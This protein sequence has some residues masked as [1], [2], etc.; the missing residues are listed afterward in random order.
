M[1]YF[2]LINSK[3]FPIITIY[4]TQRGKNT[5]FG[6]GGFWFVSKEYSGTDKGERK[7]TYE[8]K[9]YNGKV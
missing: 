3:K 7:N 8:G 5:G 4:Y 2:H 6:F 1:Y 9:K